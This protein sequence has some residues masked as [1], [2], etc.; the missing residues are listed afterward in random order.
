[1]QK[2]NVRLV[3][4]HEYLTFILKDIIIWLS[5]LCQ[6]TCHVKAECQVSNM[7]CGRDMYAKMTCLVVSCSLPDMSCGLEMQGR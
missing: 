6:P 1:M 4:C 5:H 2:Q 7:P 3:T